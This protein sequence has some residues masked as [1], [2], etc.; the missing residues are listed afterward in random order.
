MAR[1]LEPGFLSADF[2]SAA[3][4]CNF[5]GAGFGCSKDVVRALKERCETPLCR[6][7]VP[8]HVLVLTESCVVCFVVCGKRGSLAK[9]YLMTDMDTLDL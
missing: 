1:F 2:L 5:V 8:L 4:R 9:S 7:M 3:T 6:F